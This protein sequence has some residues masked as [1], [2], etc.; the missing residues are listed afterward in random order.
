ML[1]Y[2][3]RKFVGGSSKVALL[4]A[5]TL[6]LLPPLYFFGHLY[7]TD[8]PALTFV[9]LTLTASLKGKHVCGAMF[10]IAS[11]AMRQTNILWVALVLGVNSLNF[12]I[13]RAHPFLKDKARKNHQ[14]YTWKD[15]MTVVNVY[16]TRPDLIWAHGKEL[17]VEYYGYFSII[18]G[19][20][21]FLWYN[22][23]IVVGDKCAH[24]AALHVPQL[25][26]FALFTLLFAPSIVL[27]KLKPVA[28]HMLHKWYVYLA[29]FAISA[30][31]VRFNT[32]VH[33][34]LLADNRH[35]TFYLWN[36]FFNQ[37][38]WLR[39]ALIPIYV[40]ALAAIWH[41]LKDQQSVSFTVCYI[42]CTVTSIALQKLLEVRYFIL[43]Y[44]VLRVHL[45]GISP[46][47]IL[48]ELVLYLALNA[49]T[50]HLFFTKKIWWENYNEPQRLIW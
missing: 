27:S 22:G 17:I 34:Y 39:Y 9:L 7:Y 43:P 41:F 46:K 14:I 42:V 16:L 36:R 10:G 37:Y 29:I 18:F 31:I 32:L 35:Y 26:Y 15:L 3:I 12:L 6:S 33:P 24:E 25:F 1:L 21:A 45:R 50:L 28:Q 5:L 11:V 8:I 13:S 20:M 49:A 23:S 44:L 47:L 19:F 40:T 38:E 30:L 4:E 48:L 2:D